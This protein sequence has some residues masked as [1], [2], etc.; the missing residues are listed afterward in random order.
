MAK[1]LGIRGSEWQEGGEIGGRG[2]LDYVEGQFGRAFSE[3]RRVAVIEK[4]REFQVKT[5]PYPSF[6]RVARQQS[7]TD[8]EN[9]RLSRVV[10]GR[11]A[12]GSMLVSRT[13]GD[14][15]L[16]FRRFLCGF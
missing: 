13:V 16:N 9:T 15:H 12:C 3:Q 10:K 5:R 11:A 8:V 7:P 14:R 1:Q 2:W 6:S 4:G